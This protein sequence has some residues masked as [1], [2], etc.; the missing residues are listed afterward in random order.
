MAELK[1]TRATLDKVLRLADALEIAIDGLQ[2]MSDD[3]K[4]YGCVH[5]VQANEI[6]ER[7]KTKLEGTKDV[8]H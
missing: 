1:I 7:M 4:F 5:D 6:L 2:E 8:R 3:S